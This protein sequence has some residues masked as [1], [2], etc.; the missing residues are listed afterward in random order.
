MSAVLLVKTS[1]LGDVIHNLPVV[2]DLHARLPGLAIDWVVEENFAEVVRLHPGVR[3]VL[4][5][6]IRRWRRA[7]TSAQTWREAAAFRRA[8]RERHYDQVI[9][10][11]GLVKSA[12]VARLARG[13]HCGYGAEAA[14]ERLAARFYDAPFGIPRNLHAIDRNRWLVAAVMG[15]GPDGPLN[16]GIVAPP[17]LFDWLGQERYAVLLT[18]TSRDD[19]LWPEAHWLALAA[20]LADAGLSVVLPAGTEAERSRAARLAQNMSRAVLAPSLGLAPLASLLAGAA[21]VVGVDTGLSHLAA[22]VGVPVLALFCASDPELTGVRRD[23]RT[24]N[25]GDRGA[26]PAVAEVIATSMALI[27]R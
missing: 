10:T 15:Y 6:A 27:G 13:R 7:L 3:E 8:L 24:I 4:P 2:A 12:I 17:V 16:Y 26:P 20:T 1:S 21:L 5:V 11:Q 22:A 19:K 14:R 9:D 18:A 23:A 25:L